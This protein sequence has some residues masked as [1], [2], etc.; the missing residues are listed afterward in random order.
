[1]VDLL[2]FL[3]WPAL[4]RLL[5]TALQ[6]PEEEQADWLARLREP[7]SQHRETLRELLRTHARIESAGFMETLPHLAVKLDEPVEILTPGSEIGPYRI[8]RELGRGGMG[9][10]WLAERVDGLLSRPVALKLPHA[11][12][13]D[14]FAERLA[15]EREILAGLAHPHIARLYDTGLDA[16]GRPWIAMEY[17]DG[18]RIDTWCATRDLPV[19]ERLALLLQVLAA[20][21]HAHQRL[22]VHRDLKPGNILVTQDGQTMLLDFGIARLIDDG[23]AGDS[24]L[25]EVGGRAL[26]LDYASPEQIRGE[27]LG[28]ASDVYSLGVVAYELLARQRPYRLDRNHL[29]LAQATADVDPPRASDAADIP[30]L[31]NG[32]RGDIDAMLARALEKEVARRYP[33]ADAFAQDIRRHLEGEPVRARPASAAYR[34]QKFARRHRVGVAMAAVVALSVVVG[35]GVSLWQAN[36][37]RQQALEAR[38]QAN[39]A[40]SE[41]TNL[42]AVRDLYVETLMRISAMA[43]DQPAELAKPRAV[44][45]A[46]VA[47]LDDF[48]ARHADSPEQ[49]GAVLNAVMRQMT[50]MDGYESSVEVGRRYLSLLREHSAGS[51]HQIEAFLTQ[52]LHLCYLRR[53]QECEKMMREGIALAEAAPDDAEMRRL[54][55]TGRFNLGF[56]MGVLGKR[57][58]GQAILETVARDIAASDPGGKLE[59]DVDSELSFFWKGY[60]E[61]RSLDYARR[62]N[63]FLERR[64]AD[65]DQRMESRSQLGDA[66]LAAGQPAEAEATLHRSIELALPI[67]GRQSRTMNSLV[68][69]LAITV[70]AQGRH[71]QALALLDEQV[72]R[73]TST[74]GPNDLLI[75]ARLR[76]AWLSGD[77][78]AAVALLPSVDASLSRPQAGNLHSPLQFDKARTLLLLGRPAEA[79]A[80]MGK[81][82]AHWEGADRPVPGWTTVLALIGRCELATGDAAAA[83]ATAQRLVTLFD[84]LHATSGA[85]WRDANELL[86][87]ARARQG[88]RAGAARAL[89]A[90]AAVPGNF[91]S[92]VARADS[93]L[94][95]AE[96][97]RALDRP[98]AARALAAAAL[99]D[100]RDQSPASPRLARARRL[101]QEA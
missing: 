20:V 25:T 23:T 50:E 81:V 47:K 66:L 71:A 6:L 28:T 9:S 89:A 11:V 37:A 83:A 21:A 27:P 42:V 77:V 80:F 75:Q 44:Q 30:A 58:E 14:A 51:H 84:G 59:G 35:T 39:R 55:F 3:D 76:V 82:R 68:S 74:A 45:A 16:Q 10:V 48:A 93:S 8:V 2:S 13:G 86:A 98:G 61:V 53:H 88:D 79:R 69:R 78:D 73:S 92:L 100:M 64:T 56:L 22:V 97:L 70:A 33:S 18:E 85:G 91:P 46:L 65:E 26:T 72:A 1:M 5:D 43:A 60:D 41:L 4:S 36:V 29:S 40:E 101:A 67:S 63:V 94:D 19:R 90:A 31:R 52:A 49:V 34:A 17:V 87:L 95:R 54:R 32:L 62:A 7:D 24:D 12:W 38:R 57:A 96:I 99:I 15:R